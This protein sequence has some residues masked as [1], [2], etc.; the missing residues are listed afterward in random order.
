MGARESCW[1]PKEEDMAPAFPLI[2]GQAGLATVEQLYRAGYTKPM[3]RSLIAASRRPIRGVYSATP[4]PF[5]DETMLVAAALWAGP[6]ATL[7]GA[8]ALRRHGLTIAPNPALVR[9][10]VP[11]YLRSRSNA[12]GIVTERTR[13]PPSLRLLSGVRTVMIERALVDAARAG[14]LSSPSIEAHTLAVLQR[15]LTTVDRIAEQLEGIQGVRTRAVTKAVVAFRG[16]A[17]SRPEAE[18]LEAVLRDERLPA[19]VANPLLMTPSGSRI[20]IPDGYFP[21]HGVVVQVHSRQHHAEIDPTGVDQ[22]ARTLEHD[23]DYSR[24][25]LVVVPLAPRTIATNITGV[26]DTLVDVLATRN[27]WDAAR[28]VVM[29]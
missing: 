28:V 24:H 1:P 20:G 11:D 17:W 27:T 26:L 22:W 5:D 16:K 14:E 29:A 19:M 18:L 13:R 8:H 4:G 25:G 15:G 10:V 21:D 9:F 12:R 2:P 3:L 7:T 23:A 6:R